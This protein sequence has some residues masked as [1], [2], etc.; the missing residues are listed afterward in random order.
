MKNPTT[1]RARG[2]GFIVFADPTVAERVATDKHLIDHQLLQ[3]LISNTYFEQFGNITDVVV[4][5]DYKTQ[6]PRGL[7]TY[8]LE[9]SVDTV[10][11]KPFHELLN[12]KMVEV[13]RAVPRELSPGPN[14]T[15]LG[16]FNT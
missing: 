8:E 13:K 3:K 2:F 1:G 14:R 7:V 5:Y 11:L 16:G 10:L 6:R 12:G 15:V 4:M 9:E